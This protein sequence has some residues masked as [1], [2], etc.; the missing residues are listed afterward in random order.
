[1][2]GLYWREP[3]WLLAVLYPGLLWAWARWRQRGVRSG[4]AEDGLWP[5]VRAD[6][7]P[8]DRRGSGGGR[9]QRLLLAGAW[10]LLAAALAGPRLP[11]AVP[12]QARP[13]SGAL[14]AVLDLSRSMDARDVQGSRRAAARRLLQAW[15]AEPARPPLGLVVF[16]GRAHVF[17]PPSADRAAV[18]HF[19]EQLPGLNLP[20]L[21]NDLA[22]GL[23]LAAEVLRE[24][25]GHRAVVLL[26]DGDL[27]QAARER[28]ESAV[29]AWPGSGLNF[30]VLGVGSATATAV[31]DPDSG[32]LTVE[33][34]PVV[35]RLEA[36]WLQRLA[37]AGGGRY[38]AVSSEAPV[39]LGEL[40]RA[41][42]PRIAV[43]DRGQV[44]WREL[45][46]WLL[47]P[48]VLL[49]GTALLGPRVSVAAL[50]GAGILV[51][52]LSPAPVR[53]G[54]SEAAFAALSAGRYPEARSLY[55]R[56]TGYPG[57][58]GEGIACF[59]LEQWPCAAEAFAAAAWLAG[60]DQD[61]ARAA[62]NL[63]ATRYRQGDYA[64]A[65]VLFRDARAHGLAQPG[66]KT[67]I[68]FTERLAAQVEQRRREQAAGYRRAGSGSRTPEDETLDQVA[69]DRRLDAAPRPPPP[70]PTGTDPDRF[71]Q[72]IRRG[73]DRA[74]LTESAGDTTGNTG[75]GAGRAWFGGEEAA[76]ERPGTRLWQRLFE[77]EEGF[78]A[79]LS[80]PRPRPPER[81]W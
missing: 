5:W 53:A 4:Y 9:R 35:S 68:E 47:L 49:L 30:T 78:P 33:G 69:A 62:Y 70:L 73:L 15:N 25:E 54:A 81:A 11:L 60:D 44:L 71:E 61:R 50:G 43:D 29:R 52:G 76:A 28:A 66:L 18:G 8:E 48:G 64:A 6:R 36:G 57:R 7:S 14:L 1:M 51:A 19:L 23:S 22:G 16:A 56:V 41:P 3:L 32:W 13:P 10:A 42:A 40:W 20:T 39:P 77:I 67:T 17:F 80:R 37:A 75:A 74:R 59:R 58:F 38:R 55:G 24:T 79:P 72:L 26:S 2:S 65:A 34:R 63:A 31:P 12:E 46:P 27:D 45:F 21:G